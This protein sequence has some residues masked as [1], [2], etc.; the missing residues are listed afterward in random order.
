MREVWFLLVH[1]LVGKAEAFCQN[2]QMLSITTLRDTTTSDGRWGGLVLNGATAATTS[3]HTLDD[4]DGLDVAGWDP[5]KDDMAAI[6]PRGHDSGYEELRAVGVRAGV[7]HG[8]KEGP[9]VL[10]LEVLVGKLLAV[11][12]LS[13]GALRN[14]ERHV[15]AVVRD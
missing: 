2:N 3:L 15:R 14:C 7:G 8:E 4:A 13:T 9:V 11:D 5:A 1:T 6:E 12:G 10:E